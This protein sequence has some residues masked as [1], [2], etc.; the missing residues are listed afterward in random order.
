MQSLDDAT[1]AFVRYI[2]QAL[3]RAS[4]TEPK[5]L[6]R[7]HVEDAVRQQLET[8]AHTFD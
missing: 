7:Q 3:Q 4:A 8:G 2:V 6:W 5:Y 1:V